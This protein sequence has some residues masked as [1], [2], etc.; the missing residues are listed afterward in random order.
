MPWIEPKVEL[1]SMKF[2]TL[3]W[4]ILEQ[5]FAAE[6]LVGL[7]G[8]EDCEGEFGKSGFVVEVESVCEGVNGDRVVGVGA[9]GSMG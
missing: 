3:G 9:G 8:F 5:K 6:S 7:I 4:E 2:Q 1:K